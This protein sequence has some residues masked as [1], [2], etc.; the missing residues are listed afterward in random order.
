MKMT[1]VTWPSKSA[2]TL[3]VALACFALPACK[4]RT[5]ARQTTEQSPKAVQESN[6][7]AK[8]VDASIQ[9]AASSYRQRIQQAAQ[10]HAANGKLVQEAKVLAMNGVTEREQL[11]AKRELVRRFLASN[12]ALKFGKSLGLK[13]K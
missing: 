10:L 12:E 6:A 8:G 13:W 7:E 2:A 1:P 9:Q 11:E 3:L 5:D 4:Q